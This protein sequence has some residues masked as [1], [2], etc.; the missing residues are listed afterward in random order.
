MTENENDW[1]QQ[2]CCGCFTSFLFFKK[3]KWKFSIQVFVIIMD[4]HHRHRPKRFFFETPHS[5]SYPLTGFEWAIIIII[6]TKHIFPY[7]IIII[8]IA[9]VFCWIQFYFSTLQH[10][11]NKK[12]N[13]WG[14]CWCLCVVKRISIFVSFHISL[15]WKFIYSTDVTKRY[16]LFYPFLYIILWYP[17]YPLILITSMTMAIWWWPNRWMDGWMSIESI[18][19]LDFRFDFILTRFYLSTPTS[20]NTGVCVISN[21]ELSVFWLSKTI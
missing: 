21:H 2:Q 19:Q 5:L 10:R 14:C 18:L 11:N 3:N 20:R 17:F 6:I 15:K 8:I 1:V 9:V 7:L 4:F 12:K 13:W 16:S